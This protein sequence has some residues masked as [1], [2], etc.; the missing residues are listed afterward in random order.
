[1][2]CDWAR[3]QRIIESPNNPDQANMGDIK[4]AFE[5]FDSDADGYLNASEVGHV[6]RMLGCNPTNKE[7]EDMAY[8]CQDPAHISFQEVQ[9]MA[10]QCSRP[11][12]NCESELM[13]AFRVFDR[14]ENGLIMENELRVIFTTLGEAC[15]LEEINALLAQAKVD[16]AGRINYKEFIK[17]MMKV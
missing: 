17:I 6:L 1:L 9:Q 5:I 2:G 12:S 16:E 8:Q 11:N 13:E 7:A 4:S 3:Q 14:D 15:S 10:M